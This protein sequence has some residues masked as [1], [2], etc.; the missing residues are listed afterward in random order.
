MIPKEIFINSINAIE[1]Q[2]RYDK[3]SSE[4]IAEAF[5]TDYFV[6]YDN[7]Y[8]ITQVIELLSISF[9]KEEIEHYCFDLNFGK[10]SPDSNYETVEMLFERLTK[11]ND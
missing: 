2:M 9:D 5:G 11:K 10:P 8:L 3:K 1:K 4:L 6:L 7:S